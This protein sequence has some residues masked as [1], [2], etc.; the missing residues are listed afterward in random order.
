MIFAY[1]FK[2]HIAH[3]SILDIVVSKLC[4]KKKPYLIILFEV[5]K[6]S[7]ICFY[8]AILSFSLAICLLIKDNKKSLFNAKK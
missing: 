5:D 4:Y 6:S 2:K 7:K 3:N 8:Y 1:K